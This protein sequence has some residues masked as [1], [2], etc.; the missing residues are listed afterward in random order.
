VISPIIPPIGADGPVFASPKTSRAAL[1]G[2]FRHRGA[3]GEAVLLKA[4]EAL[5]SLRHLRLA[6]SR[7]ADAAF[8]GWLTNQAGYSLT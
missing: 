7:P 5:Q 3:S 2:L 8:H 6:E 4:I 1:D